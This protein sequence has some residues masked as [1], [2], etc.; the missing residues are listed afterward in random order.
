MVLVC[1][2]HGRCNFNRQWLG[3]LVVFPSAMPQK[4]WKVGAHITPLISWLVNDPLYQGLI[5]PLFLGGTLGRVGWLA[6]I[7]G[8][9]PESKLTVRPWKSMVGRCFFFRRLI[10]WCELLVSGTRKGQNISINSIYKCSSKCA[11]N[12]IYCIVICNPIC[13]Q[14]K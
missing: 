9:L 8:T 6:M 12:A 1:W 7:R 2:P 14:F 13:D 5:K 11:V 4:P 10:F 3:D